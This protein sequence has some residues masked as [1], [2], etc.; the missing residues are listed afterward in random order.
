[1][2]LQERAPG[3]VLGLGFTLGSIMTEAMVRVEGVDGSETIRTLYFLGAVFMA[4]A[5]VLANEMPRRP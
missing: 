2:T 5:Y 4:Y 1:M 3:F